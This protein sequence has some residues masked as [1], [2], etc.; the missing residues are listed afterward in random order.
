MNCTKCICPNDYFGEHCEEVVVN[1]CDSN[2]CING[3]TCLENNEEYTCVC[4]NEWTGVNCETNRCTDYCQNGGLCIIIDAD[5]I[6]CNCSQTGFTGPT[7]EDEVNPCKPDI[8][9]NGG[10]CVPLDGHGIICDCVDGYSGPH[11]EDIDPTCLCLNGGQCEFLEGENVCFC[12][13]EFVG[14]I[15]EH[16]NPCVPNPCNNGGT[17][18][19]QHD[20]TF[21][22]TCTNGWTDPICDTCQDTSDN[23]CTTTQPELLVEDSSNNYIGLI[24]G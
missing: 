3:G 21:T 20:Y 22:C 15:C 13:D 14:P 24:I 9:Q 7:C 4:P 5:N 10:S 16:R 8:C 1:P 12:P 18:T 17:C 11:C 23:E 19:V 6:M 2:P